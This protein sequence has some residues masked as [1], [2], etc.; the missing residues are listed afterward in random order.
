MASPKPSNV[1]FHVEDREA[2]TDKVQ[3]SFDGIE[4]ISVDSERE[5]KLLRKIDLRLMCSL[6]VLYLFSYMDRSNI[7]NA[8]VAGMDV[9]LDLTDSEYSTAIVVFVV[10]YII[11]QVPSNMFLTRLRPSLYIPTMMILWGIVVSFMGMIKTPAQLI[12]LRLLLGLMEASFVP[13]VVFLI[14]MWYKKT[15]QSKRFMFFTSAAIL[16]G[17]FGGIV[18]GAITKTLDGAHGISGWRWLFIV[19][20]AATVGI[21]LI[22][23]WC[24]L[25]YPATSKALTEE[26]RELAVRRLV[27]D[28]VVASI[29]GEGEISHLKALKAALSNWRL[30]LLV[31][32]YHCI[33]ST[34]SLSY[35]YPYIVRSL[36]YASV[37]AQF[38]TAPIYF[39]AFAIAVPC[40]VLA[41][42]YPNKRVVFVTTAMFLGSIFCILITTVLSDVPRYVFLCF[43]TACIWTANPIAESFASS[44]MASIQPEVR[45]ISLAFINSVGNLAQIYGS[46]LLP[47]WD[48]PR[49]SRGFGT[50]AGLLFIGGCVYCAAMI[51]LRRR[52]FKLARTH[53]SP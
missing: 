18:A 36:G 25:D 17:A 23:P 13:A 39:T 50:F 20:G 53:A 19:E 51:L 8:H 1:D 34:L 24:L 6:W 38:M 27:E 32:G 29:D 9:A 46:Y 37:Q 31:A 26:E 43:L 45:A 3:T 48:A 40:C 41:D 7:G 10:G 30:W 47:S 22:A 16:A 2:M 42:R 52:P 44:S 21:G 4:D 5:R 11:G 33:I 15:E 49:H 12:G 35:F 28:G 14:S